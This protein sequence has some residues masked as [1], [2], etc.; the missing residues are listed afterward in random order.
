MLVL[1]GESAALSHS[2]RR[3]YRIV[4]ETPVLS[5]P[6]QAPAHPRYSPLFLRAGDRGGTKV[7]RGGAESIVIVLCLS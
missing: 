7:G 4:R 6:R 1:E 3:F 2:S 5:L